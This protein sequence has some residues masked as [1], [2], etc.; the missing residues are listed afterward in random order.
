MTTRVTELNEP[1][2]GW[3]YHSGTTLYTERF[4]GGR[5]LAASLQDTG[6]PRYASDEDGGTAAFDL[7]VDGESL[8]FGWDLAEATITGEDLGAPGTRIVLRHTLKPVE[9][10]LVTIAGGDGF[11]RR[12]IRLENTSATATLGLTAVTPL[13]GVLWGMEDNLRENLHGTGR[14]PYRV[15]WMQDNEW[16]N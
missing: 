10:E 2:C 8:S 5:L 3:R 11:F 6:V 7:Q 16:G 4:H 12:Q 1:H 9:L 14:V 13:A 15:G